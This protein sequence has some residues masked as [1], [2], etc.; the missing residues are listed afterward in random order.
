MSPLPDTLDLIIS[1]RWIVPVVP[2]GSV[3][4]GHSLAVHQG[5]ILAILPDA[6]ANEL[7]ALERRVLPDHVLIP[8]LVNA[9]GH[10][11]MSLFRGLADDL[12]LMTWLNQHIWP[13]EG[14]WVSE[15]FVRVGTQLAVAEMLRGGTTCFADMYFFPDI[16]ARVALDA[17]MRAQL[18]FPVID[19]PIPGA[20]DS[21][22]A[23]SKGLRLH[24]EMKHSGL[25]SIAFGPHAPYTV[26][27]E[28]LIRVRTL[29]DELELPVHMHIH[30]TAFE[31]EQA[32]QATGMRPL[33]RLRR[34]GLLSPRLQAVHMTQVDD[35]DL[36]LLHDFAVQIVHCPESNMKLAS[37]NCPVQRLLEADINVALGTDGA[38][39][40]NDLDMFGEMRT[41]ALLAK[42]LSGQPTAVDA[43]RA[44]H[45]ATLGG[46]M[47]LGLGEQTGSLEPGKFADL[48]AINLGGLASQP[49]YHPV[50]QLL[51]T[52]NASQVSDVW[53]AGRA[54][55]RDGRLLLP[56]QD[57][58]L[59]SVAHWAQQIKQGD[60]H[61]A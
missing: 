53:V 48:A 8:G 40:N 24:D 1:A 42:S 51:Y 49:V 18:A 16:A 59:Q 55:V 39:S 4:E 22:E 52:C 30:E 58:L 57:Q 26:G 20:R 45:M 61:D 23:I 11:A 15:D 9:H 28:T 12:P 17:G 31:V 7:Q 33:E 34:L 46:A 44:L 35:T 3:L 19:N 5:R 29:A 14:K 38:A 21:A 47:A 36:Q 50:S 25:I 6:R 37:G 32:V 10:A 41:A 2:A 27:D 43:H 56:G 54:K 60:S 13:A